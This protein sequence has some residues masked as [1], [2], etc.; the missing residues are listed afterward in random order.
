MVNRKAGCVGGDGDGDGTSRERHRQRP[1]LWEAM[2]G[3][4]LQRS[5]RQI[6][7]EKEGRQIVSEIGRG[8]GSDGRVCTF[9]GWEEHHGYARGSWVIKVLD[10][11]ALQDTVT[12]YQG[13]CN[14]C[15]WVWTLK[16]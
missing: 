2:A 9:R 4:S 14:V 12:H 15:R 7:R 5:H 3:A 10:G 1:A 6:E 8:C 13:V 11:D 16:M